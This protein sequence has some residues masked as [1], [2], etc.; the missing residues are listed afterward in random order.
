MQDSEQIKW[1]FYLLSQNQSPTLIVVFRRHIKELKYFWKKS[2]ALEVLQE[3][4]V[5]L[6]ERSPEAKRDITFTP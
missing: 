2:D 6:G 4:N 5:K 1:C 3:F